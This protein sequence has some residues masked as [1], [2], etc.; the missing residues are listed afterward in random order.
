MGR[1]ARARIYYGTWKTRAR[2]GGVDSHPLPP[3]YTSRCLRR[4][5]HTAAARGGAKR[6]IIDSQAPESFLFS[7]YFSSTTF[8]FCKPNQSHNFTS[9]RRH[10]LGQIPTPRLAPPCTA[11]TPTD[12]ALPRHLPRHCR[13]TDSP[14]PVQTHSLTALALSHPPAASRNRP[15]FLLCLSPK[16]AL[17]I[18]PTNPLSHLQH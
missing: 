2:N 4:H 8:A 5:S 14:V 6:R 1:H 12:K 10:S 11:E 9:F 15:R 16:P 18:S 7:S 3:V 13:P 17:N